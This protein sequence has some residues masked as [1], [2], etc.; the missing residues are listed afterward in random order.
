ML[1]RLTETH[2][3]KKRQYTELV[4]FWRPDALGA[5]LQF[6]RKIDS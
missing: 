1:T 5:R 4:N 2:R 6:E 3:L